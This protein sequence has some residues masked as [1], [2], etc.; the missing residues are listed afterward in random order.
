MGFCFRFSV[1]H[2]P[3]SSFHLFEVVVGVVFA[4]GG[5]VVVGEVGEEGLELEEEALAGG[6]AV[7]G[8][9]E[10]S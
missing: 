4:G 1:F 3:L 9:V 10:F 5:K 8:H 2:F 6:V 7:G